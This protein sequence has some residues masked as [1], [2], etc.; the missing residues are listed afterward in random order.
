[1]LAPTQRT[2]TLPP[3]TIFLKGVHQW[4]LNLFTYVA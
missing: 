2:A 1:M 3:N 4:I